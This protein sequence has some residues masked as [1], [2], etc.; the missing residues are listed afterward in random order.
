MR[1]AAKKAKTTY[2]AVDEMAGFECLECDEEYEYNE[3]Y[4]FSE[5]S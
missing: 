2:P 4:C 3:V 5:S 1:P